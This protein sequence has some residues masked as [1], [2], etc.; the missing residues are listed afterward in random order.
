MRSP[1][2]LEGTNDPIVGV[3]VGFARALRRAGVGVGSGDV[4]T[5]CAA[6]APLDP[7]DLVDLYWAGSASLVRSF[8]DMATYDEVFKR[9]FLT[10][11]APA[12]M[13]MLELHETAGAEAIVNLPAAINPGREVD[14]EGAVLGVTA[15]AAE[16]LKHKSFAACTPDELA[17][18]RRIMARMRIVSP[19]RRTRRSI[20]APAGA[21]P[22]L[23]RMMRESMRM[24]GEPPQ[25]LWRRR[26]L[27]MRPLILVLDISG[28]MADYSRSLVQ[29][30]YG[31]RRST[32]K[33][34]V[35]CFATRLTRITPQLDHAQPDQALE[36]AAKGVFDWEGGTRI[37]ESIESL[38]RN[39]AR[40]GL[41]RGGI[42]VICSD[43]L[44]RGDPRVLA[45]AMARLSRLCHRV[46]WMNPHKGTNAEFVPATLGMMAC[47]PYIDLLASG[48]NLASLEELASILPSI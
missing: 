13:R 21:L 26:G 5:F 1:P 17:S 2:V 38:V 39:W 28:S 45:E 33:V 12:E 37:G 4:I 42:V 46:V 40:R 30:A 9:Y 31:A 14:P 18:L 25:L 44:D 3:L 36:A 11:R 19:R 47:E 7:T 48:H 41:F 16:A 10:G 29:F 32:C 27:R 34:E 20:P 15:S 43:G 8:E 6:M 35:F 22:D 24:R 23:R